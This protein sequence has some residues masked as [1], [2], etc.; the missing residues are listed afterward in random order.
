MQKTS[1]L[2]P[3]TPV[4]E[5]DREREYELEISGLINA[6]SEFEEIA[7]VRRREDLESISPQLLSR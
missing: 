5:R 4:T 6:P 3:A 7:W 1:G 2:M